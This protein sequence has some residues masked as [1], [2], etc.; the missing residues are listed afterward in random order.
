M[1]EG[2]IFLLGSVGFILLSRQALT[3]PYSH[4]FP[5]FFAFEALLGLGVVNAPSW[6]IRPLS[7]QQI[8]SWALLILATYLVGHATWALRKHG[9]P[10]Q[11]LSDPQR[12]GIEKT[13]RLVTTGP[14]RPLRHP[15]YT[16]LLCLGWGIFL[17]QINL[18]SALLVFIICM[19]VFLTTIYEERENLKIFGEEYANYMRKTWRFIPFVF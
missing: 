1:V 16:S 11:R 17:K 8:I 14:Y 9:A 7:I 15:M 5:R 12:V 10:D 19:T 2:I 3:R 13:T 6:F 18:I 4:G